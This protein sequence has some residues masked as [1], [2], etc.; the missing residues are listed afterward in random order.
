MIDAQPTSG[1]PSAAPFLQV[2]RGENDGWRTRGEPRLRLGHEVSRN[3]GPPDGVWLRWEWDGRRLA[4]EN[5]RFGFH[6][7]VYWHHPGGIAVSPTPS[8]LL[9]AGAPPDLDDA[10]LAVFLRFG[11]LVGEDTPFAALRALPPATRLTWEDGELHLERTPWQPP[12]LLRIERA[13]ALDAY[14]ELFRQAVKRRPPVGRTAMPLSGGRDS[15][16]ILLALCAL[17]RPPEVCVTAL[18]SPP[19]SNRDAE[20]AVGVA[21]ALGL[22]HRVLPARAGRV[23]AELEKN[24]ATGF[25]SVEHIF[26]LPLADHFSS[27]GTDTVY[28]GIAG[29]VLSAGLFLT[30]ERHARMA[31]GRFRELCGEL[32][33]TETGLAALLTPGAVRRF[34]REAAEARLAAEM[35]RHAGAANPV[36]SFYFWNRTR[37]N[38]A[39]V[40]YAVLRAVPRVYAPY[41]DHDLFDFLSA[42]PAELLVDHQFHTD[43]IRAGYPAHAGLPF[44]EKERPGPAG[45]PYFRRI[46]FETAAYLRQKRASGLVRRGF[47]LPRLAHLAAVPRFPARQ[48]WWIRVALYLLQLEE[49]A[50]LHKAL[51]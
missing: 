40:P 42:L 34:S 46:A 29:D 5:D 41:L 30:P 24:R 8:A 17:G 19:R 4:V 47:L 20:V 25:G 45:G 26:S 16:H 33:G 12:P 31:E 48:A 51:W 2:L 36:G 6:P 44:E 10:A 43:A 18:H 9:E 37:R 3:G 50:D 39:L 15:R 14:V 7:L 35:E 28:D 27:S 21:A 13:A 23:D 38:I 32:L 1:V 22:P 11:Q 49:T